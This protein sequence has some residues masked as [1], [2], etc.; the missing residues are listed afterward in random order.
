MRVVQLLENGKCQKEK[1]S[2]VNKQLC[3]R[4]RVFVLAS[5][6]WRDRVVNELH[7]GREGG[8]SSYLRTYKRISRNFA[9]PGMKKLIK[10]VVAECGTCQRNHY[11][12]V[13]PPGLLQPNK[14][15]DGA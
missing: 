11:E 3:Y 13:L 9:W 2:F 7:G 15:P 10:R 12:T 14:I 1:F 6:N 8:H 5:G 4:N